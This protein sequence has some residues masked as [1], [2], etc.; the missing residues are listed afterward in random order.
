MPGSDGNVQKTLKGK[1]KVFFFFT[2]NYY[3]SKQENHLS[4][5]TPEIHLTNVSLNIFVSYALS[6]LCY[7]Q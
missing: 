1:K 3:I 5:K 7:Q 4:K 2:N 6:N